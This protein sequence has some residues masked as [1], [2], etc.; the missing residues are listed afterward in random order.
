MGI[1]DA[2]QQSLFDQPSAD[3]PATVAGTLDVAVF[4]VRDDVSKG[5][6]RS[7]G[8][9]YSFGIPRGPW[10]GSGMR[11][12]VFFGVDTRRS[13]AF[14]LAIVHPRTTRSDADRTIEAT[15]FTTIKEMDC[16]DADEG[17]KAAAQVDGPITTTLGAELLDAIAESSSTTSDV[18][19]HLAA[20]LAE[21]DDSDDGSRLR[22][23]RDAILLLTRFAHMTDLPM[24]A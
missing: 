21:I 9:A 1:L 17:A 10:A 5:L 12:G 18:I 2:D 8:G 4:H 24:R 13:I 14:G 19:E 22:D 20:K 7:R 3:Q 23:E 15:H 16:S 11:L 6:A